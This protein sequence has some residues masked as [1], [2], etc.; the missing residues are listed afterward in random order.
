[1]LVGPTASGDNCRSGVMGC[2]EDGSSA[3][4]A[5]PPEAAAARRMAW[6]WGWLLF[7][8]SAFHSDITQVRNT[9]FENSHFLG[10]S[11]RLQKIP[12][13]IFAGWAPVFSN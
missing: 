11:W 4:L 9:V 12:D 3:C 2:K 10:F 13:A 5:R 7:S 8:P 6:L 1:M